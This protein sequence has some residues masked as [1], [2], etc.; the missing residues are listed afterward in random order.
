MH[1][2]LKKAMEEIKKSNAKTEKQK[3]EETT[4]NEE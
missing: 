1:D 2:K 4:K 3:K